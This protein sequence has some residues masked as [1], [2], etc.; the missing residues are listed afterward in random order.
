MTDSIVRRPQGMRAEG[1]IDLTKRPRVANQDH[2]YSTL[3]SMSVGMP[4]GEVLVPTV[5]EDGWYMS[6]DQAMRR[7]E[8]L[9]RHLGIFDS[10]DHATDYAKLLSLLQGRP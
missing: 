7:Y 2:S 9:G 10:P 8:Q 5:R 3:R 1:N 6:P 4:E